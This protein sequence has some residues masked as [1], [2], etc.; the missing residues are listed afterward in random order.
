MF[1][2]SRGG[3]KVWALSPGEDQLTE[4]EDADPRRAAWAIGVIA[5]DPAHPQR[6]IAAL[7]LRRLYGLARRAAAEVRG[8]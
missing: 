1:S 6:E 2:P 3:S 5:K 8:P 4:I 7:A